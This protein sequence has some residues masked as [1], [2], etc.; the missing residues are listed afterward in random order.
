[1]LLRNYFSFWKKIYDSTVALSNV[2]Y[3]ISPIIAHS[4]L[5]IASHLKAYENKI[6]SQEAIVA[7]KT[8][9][10]KYWKEIPIICAFAFILDHR[11]KIQ[12][13]TNVLQLVNDATIVDYSNYF[14]DIRAKFSEIYQKYEYKF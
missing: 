11:A 10:L 4:I 14:V 3:P 1:M 7:M 13:F 9:C 6:V 5:E 8:K 12:R 2:Y